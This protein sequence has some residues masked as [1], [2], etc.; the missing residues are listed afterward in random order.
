M[1]TG[2]ELETVSRETPALPLTLPD[3]A[4]ATPAGVDFLADARAEA[5]SWSPNTRRAYVAGWNHFTSWCIEHRC[6]GPAVSCGRRRPL[7]RAPGG[8]GRQDAGHRPPAPSG[9][10]R[11]AP[12]GL[13]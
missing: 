6:A 1:T 5:R 10:R 3:G 12:P 8:N 7:H 2:T 11:G 9:D 4:P 13:T